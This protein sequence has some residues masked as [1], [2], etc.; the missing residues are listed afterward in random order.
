MAD[1]I[2]V[3]PRPSTQQVTNA[4]GPLL[5]IKAVFP[6]DLFPEEIIV[7]RFKIDVIKK[8]FF[9]TQNVITI[10]LSG[11]VTVNV[12]KSLFFSSVEIHDPSTGVK[13][14][15]TTLTA[16]DAEQFRKLI[17]G[18]VVGIRQGINFMGMTNEEVNANSLKWGAIEKT[19]ALIQSTP[20]V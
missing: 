3:V 18:L 7:D 8:D 13:A 1:Q 15:V 12:Y 6:F 19:D 17:L 16:H 20:L 4:S 2:Q 9:F 5:W 14:K 10:P 11:T